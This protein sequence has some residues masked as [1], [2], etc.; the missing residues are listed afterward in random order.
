M[1][2]KGAPGVLGAQEAPL[3]PLCRTSG[4]DLTLAVHTA[5]IDDSVHSSFLSRMVE[6]SNGDAIGSVIESR[7]GHRQAT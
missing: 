3:G 7:R 6:I 2:A 4:L 5:G 1:V